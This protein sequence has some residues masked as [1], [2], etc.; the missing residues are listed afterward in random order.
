MK[1]NI[2]FIPGGW[3]NG[4]LVYAYS[5]RFEETPVFLQREDCIEN[6]KNDGA[7]YGFDNISLLTSEKYGPETT[8][9]ARC[10]FED[11]GAP[12]IVLADSMARDSRG[13]CRY[14]D[15]LEV[16]LWKNGVNVW[17]MWMVNGTVTW[18]QLLG[19][20][21]PVSEGEAHTLS[22]TAHADSL[23]ITA[24]GRKMWLHV[25]EL[26]PAFHVDINA[27]E[28]INRFYSFRVS[29]PETNIM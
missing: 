2:S 19:V 28:G 11:L 23:E 12:L 3:D 16:V 22:V 10:A 26:Y 25:P 20:E 13:V 6:R 14:G 15:Y 17:R 18:K 7:V 5:Y 29:K 4:E 27:C 24:D 21:F 8:V 1:K 9:T